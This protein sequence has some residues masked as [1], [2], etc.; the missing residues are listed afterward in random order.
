MCL[1]EQVYQAQTHVVIFY[2][3]PDIAGALHTGT[4]LHC[5]L[6]DPYSDSDDILLL[7]DWKVHRYLSWLGSRNI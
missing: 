7:H 1:N 5:Y 4:A 3:K 2:E 6:K